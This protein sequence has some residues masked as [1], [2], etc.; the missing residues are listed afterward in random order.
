MVLVLVVSGIGPGVGSGSDPHTGTG[1]S[2]GT[3]EITRYL[4]CL[5]VYMKNTNL[6]D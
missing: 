5:M 1:S 3:L 6:N 2:I 4:R